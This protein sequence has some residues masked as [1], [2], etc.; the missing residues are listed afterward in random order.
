MSKLTE[1]DI[2]P[3][4]FPDLRCAQT[5]CA[6][7]HGTLVRADLGSLT[8]YDL[9]FSREFGEY[10][11]DAVLEAGEEFGAGPAGVDAMDRLRA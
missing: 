10:L 3:E 2:S 7:I 1:L 4:A 11:W 8:S 6:E 9:Y 5:R